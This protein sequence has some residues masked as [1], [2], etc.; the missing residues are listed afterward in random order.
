MSSAIRSY[1]AVTGH[2]LPSN[3]VKIESTV[4]CLIDSNDAHSAKE[5]ASKIK[6]E[7]IQKLKFKENGV[8][9]ACSTTDNATTMIAVA[10]ELN[11]K[12]IPCYA[13]TLQLAI[14]DIQGGA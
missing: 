10:K 6:T 14:S 13:H 3:A 1:L 9:I 8:T 11:I 4:L 12:H 5:Y 2:F 7:V